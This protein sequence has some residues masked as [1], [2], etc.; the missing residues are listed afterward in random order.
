[1]KRSEALLVAGPLHNNEP[2]ADEVIG[3]LEQFPVEGVGTYRVPHEAPKGIR[4]LGYTE[5]GE[6][7]GS[8]LGGHFPGDKDSKDPEDRV[9]ARMC[10]DL[11]PVAHWLGID[12]H[13]SPSK[14]ANFVA[15]S[16]VT[17]P[18]QLG[19]ALALGLDKVAVLHDYPFFRSFPRFVS[20]ETTR[21][22]INNP[23]SCP[24]HWRTQLKQIVNLGQSGLRRLFEQ[25]GHNLTYYRGVSI[26][27]IGQSALSIAQV[28]RLERIPV[29]GECF[30]E[31][32]LPGDLATLLGVENRATSIRTWNHMNNA[33]ERPDLGVTH[34][35]IQRRAFFGSLFV[36]VAPPIKINETTLRFEAE[37]SR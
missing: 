32:E 15:A 11:H 27:L 21:D 23:L 36:A 37:K 19:L 24:A 31:I 30:E 16:N 1:M 5:D 34:E 6:E 25:D 10:S 29:S 35:G 12:I 28:E 4:F 8:E 26:P 7:F 20:V 9:A 2:T 13:D 17:A 14:N 33:K 3:D 22:P 18:E